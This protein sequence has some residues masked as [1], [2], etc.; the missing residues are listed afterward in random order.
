MRGTK[1]CK[2]NQYEGLCNSEKKENLPRTVVKDVDSFRSVVSGV[3]TKQNEK[4]IKGKYT[5]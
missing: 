4:V 2:L 5:H 1:S 3:M